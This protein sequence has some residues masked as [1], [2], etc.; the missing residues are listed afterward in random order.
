M[1]NSNGNFIDPSMPPPSHCPTN[2]PNDLTPYK[3]QLDFKIAEFLFSCNQM[4]GGD[5]NIFFEL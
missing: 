2:D 3:S 5:I 4:L 1:H